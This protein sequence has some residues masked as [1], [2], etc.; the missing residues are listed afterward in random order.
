VGWINV[1]QDY[2]VLAGSHA[3]GNAHLCSQIGW[4]FHEQLSNC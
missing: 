3:H 1:A 4:E 2:G